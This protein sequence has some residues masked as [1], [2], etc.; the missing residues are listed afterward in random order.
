MASFGSVVT[1][2]NNQNIFN[3]NFLKNLLVVLSPY[4]HNRVN[5]SLYVFPVSPRKPLLSDR[6]KKKQQQTILD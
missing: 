4:L 1:L 5:K 2:I 6:T 3:N